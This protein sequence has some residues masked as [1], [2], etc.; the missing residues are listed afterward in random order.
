MYL[1]ITG[2]YDNILNYFIRIF[3]RQHFILAV[4]PLGVVLSSGKEG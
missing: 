2:I 1:V 3:T 4:T